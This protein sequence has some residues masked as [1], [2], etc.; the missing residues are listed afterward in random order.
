[1][2]S[3]IG[4]SRW[5]DR[6]VWRTGRAIF[7]RTLACLLNGSADFSGISPLIT[8]MSDHALCTSMELG[9]LFLQFIER[10]HH[11]LLEADG[12]EMGK[13][14]FP[15]I[16][17]NQYFY[18]QG[19]QRNENITLTGL[20]GMMGVSKPSATVAITKLIHDGFIIRTRSD[21]DQRKF[22]LSLSGKGRE[23]FVHKQRAYRKFIEQLEQCTTA[24]EQEI[25]KKAFRI[26]VGCSPEPQ[27]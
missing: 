11:I 4:F 7:R 20:A 21:V 8:L 24:K 18:L 26:M 1:M 6:I 14:G 15:D 19:V 9:D 5:N 17:I 13:A 16:T 22:H 27:E 12:T 10:Y 25:L 2:P 23:V 3:R